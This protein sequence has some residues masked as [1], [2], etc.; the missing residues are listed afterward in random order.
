LAPFVGGS[1]PSILG[2]N[3]NLQEGCCELENVEFPAV[4]DANRRTNFTGSWLWN[5][6]RFMTP[7]NRLWQIQCNGFLNAGCNYENGAQSRAGWSVSYLCDGA[8][9]NPELIF[10]NGTASVMLC[11]G[12]FVAS[13]A[14]VYWQGGSVRDSGD[15]FP[16]GSVCAIN[17]SHIFTFIASTGERFLISSEVLSHD[18]VAESNSF[19]EMVAPVTH[20]GAG[21]LMRVRQCS[22]GRL[23]QNI[24]QRGSDASLLAEM[25]SNIRLDT[26][27]LAFG[28]AHAGASVALG[29]VTRAAGVSWSIGDAVCTFANLPKD[30]SNIYRAS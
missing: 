19:I 2:V 25:F 16:H 9:R 20:E 28:A 21:G 8:F 17:G 29:R 11:G 15:T 7:F 27:G 23:A 1:L 30:V 3:D 13:Q 4:Q 6:V 14:K 18:L 24:I 26:T 5:G 10:S 12:R 22:N